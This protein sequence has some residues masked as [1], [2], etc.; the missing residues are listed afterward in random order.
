[1][2]PSSGNEFYD[3]DQ[4]FQQYLQK[5]ERA[6]NPNDLIEKPIFLSLTNEISGHVLD[7]GCGYGD[8]ALEL[9]KRGAS[10]YTG[11]DASQKMINLA[12]EKAQDPAIHFLQ[13]DIEKWFY[14]TKSY[15]WIISRLALHYIDDLAAL[16][17]KIHQS[18]KPNG[19]LL[20]SVEH[21]VL[22]SSM[23]LPRPKGKKQGWQ[24]DQYFEQGKREQVWMDA[25]VIKYHRTLEAFW[26]LLKGAGFQV[27]EIREGRPNAKYFARKEE[28]E[29]RKRI[30]LFLI[31]KAIHT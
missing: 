17:Q 23:N 19:K 14:E 15:D 21:P 18:L 12:K 10:Q 1:M 9:I 6:E 2:P 13:S 27:E 5:R 24:V 22:T 4:V 11:I 28:F 29:R 3:E 7:L 8:I 16:F 25:Q 31:I 26:Q 30:P 20:F